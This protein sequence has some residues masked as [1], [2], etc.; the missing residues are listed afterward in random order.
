MVVGRLVGTAKAEKDESNQC[1]AADTPSA[2]YRF[3]VGTPECHCA[4]V[5]P[6]VTL[7]GRIHFG[8]WVL[9]PFHPTGSF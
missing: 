9:A 5:A 7:R 6:E 8:R 1:Q 3:I 2:N 4:G